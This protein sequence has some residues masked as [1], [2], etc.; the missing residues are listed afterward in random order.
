MPPKGSKLISGQGS[1]AGYFSGGKI[2]RAEEAPSAGGGSSSSATPSPAKKA[3]GAKADT[4]S[5]G[6]ASSSKAASPPAPIIKEVDSKI[7]V[8]GYT[9]AKSPELSPVKSK[10]PPVRSRAPIKDDSDDEDSNMVATSSKAG[11]GSAGQSK[12]FASGGKKNSSSSRAK[13]EVIDVDD[14]DDYEEE[15]PK[16]KGKRAAPKAPPARKGR[17]VKDEDEDEEGDDD[18]DGFEHEDEDEDEPPKKKSKTASAKSTPAKGAPKKPAGANAGGSKASAIDLDDEEQDEKPKKQA[19]KKDTSADNKVD[20]AALAA[21]RARAAEGPSNPGSKEIPEGKPNCLAGLTFVFTGQLESLAREDAQALVK[22]LGAK[23]TGAPSSK[24][25]FVVLGEDAGPSKLKKIKEAKI[26]TLTEDGLLDLIRSRGDQPMDEETKRKLQEEKDKIMKLAAKMEV[27][28]NGA[29][30]GSKGPKAVDHDLQSLWTVK[31]APSQAKDLMGNNKQ[32][33]KLKEWLEAW[34]SSLAANFKKPGKNAT[35]IYRAMLISGPP[36]IGKTTAAHLMA[37]L[38]GYAP[39]ELNA[40]DTRS[41]RLIEDSLKNVINNKS[42][43]GWYN[44]SGGG[45]KM[46]VQGVTITDR[47][48]LILDEVDGMSGGDRGGIGAINQLIKKTRI[49]IILIANDAKSQKM[50][51]FQNT[52]YALPFQ[53]PKAD[54]VRA[55]L[56]TIAYREKLK[57][58]KNVMDQL[59]L[60]AQSDLRSVINMLSTFRLGQKATMSFDE[61]KALGAANMKEGVG[62]PFNV[63]SELSSHGTWAASSK[64]NLNAKA[65]YYFQDPNIIPLF[66]AENYARQ[67]P[68]RVSSIK[69]EKQKEFEAL[70]LAN[71]AASSIS[72]G[73]VVDSMIHGP[74]Q[75]WGLMPLHAIVSTVQPM[76]LMHGMTVQGDNRWGPAFP[77]WLG[78][79]S[80]QQRLARATVELQV[81]MRLSASGSK[82]EV[83]EHYAPYLFDALSRPLV[84]NKEKEEAIEEVIKVMDEYYLGLEDR[85]NVLE[86]G[87]GEHN[88]DARMKKVP[89]ATKSAFTRSYNGRSHP[90]A[91]QKGEAGAARAKA[92][93]LKGDGVPDVEEAIVEDD[94]E[95]DVEDMSDDDDDVDVGKDKMIKEK[96][97]KAKAK[98]KK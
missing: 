38:C 3:K 82:W 10:A 64:K 48:V 53:R 29:G 72:D 42:L 55:R 44:G 2:T 66:V 70:K 59:I 51:P 49:P 92:K 30:T 65:D 8:R 23:V 16:A 67:Q 37:K 14:D 81:K 40:S 76:S 85:D 43:D 11:D 58:D 32:I 73:D 24:T 80:K 22:R 94:G 26:D 63:Y 39:I 19:A 18:D 78:N 68:Q 33:E 87:I 4:K 74:Q 25:S 89:T 45:G 12:Y 77:A 93:Q 31:Y 83:R 41:K 96:K 21:S 69:N 17:K 57:I 98:A 5:K 27:S 36:G 79:N 75:H 61:G 6:G 35:N 95:Y 88:G 28:E 62:N 47:S 84:D 56:L 60:S 71:R 1:L 9:P 90:I 54:S 20:Q 97:P 46:E 86:L 15:A 50:K 91:F 7:T 34:P 13:K 52:S